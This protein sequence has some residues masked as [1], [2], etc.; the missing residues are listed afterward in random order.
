M[1]CQGQ[2]LTETLY[3]LLLYAGIWLYLV[4]SSRERHGRL[5]G[6]LLSG[7][8]LSV[9]ALTRGNG[10]VAF[11]GLFALLF[12]IGTRRLIGPVVLLAGFLPLVLAWSWHNYE[13]YGYFKPTPAGSYN[14]AVTLVGPAKRA[15]LGLPDIGNAEVWK[16]P[17]ETFPNTFRQA[18]VVEARALTYAKDHVAQVLWSNVTGW[19]RALGNGALLD[20]D[21][22]WGVRG[23]GVLGGVLRAALFLLACWLLFVRKPANALWPVGDARLTAT[24]LFGVMFCA[25]VLPSGGSGHWR[26]TFPL[27]MLA[28][29]L[30]CG[31]ICALWHNYRE[32]VRNSR[33]SR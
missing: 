32:L 9:A 5:M 12:F 20:W 17:G 15:S 19:A 13:R 8:V 23:W 25:H 14:V 4:Y 31:A 26:L 33:S 11:F 24:G 1:V 28:V 7:F 18:E 22:I 10:L 16:M 21:K 3:V 2:I 27:D 6:I 30:G 29:I